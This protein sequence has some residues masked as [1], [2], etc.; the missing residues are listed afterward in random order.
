MKIRNSALI[1]LLTAGMVM[2][3]SVPDSHAAEPSYPMVCRAGGS[4]RVVHSPGAPENIVQIDFQRAASAAS[5]T[6]PRPGQCAWLDR[7]IRTDEPTILR[8]ASAPPVERAYVF[9]HR[10]GGIYV[11]LRPEARGDFAYLLRAAER[12]DVFYVK[13]YQYRGRGERHFVITGTGP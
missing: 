8:L 4:M 3:G 7:P 10:P 5:R 12:G 11:E 6:Q 9:V 2:T 13:T 1:I